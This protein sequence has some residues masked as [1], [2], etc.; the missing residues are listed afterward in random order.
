ME[1]LSGVRKPCETTLPHA[2]LASAHS[3]LNFL[4]SFKRILDRRRSGL[5]RRLS[6]TGTNFSD[7]KEPG[8]M[9]SQDKAEEDVPLIRT[10][11]KVSDGNPVIHELI[12]DS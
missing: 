11:H 1:L 5:G 3:C 7:G 6:F 9:D 4:E 12:T 2:T 10:E 8:F